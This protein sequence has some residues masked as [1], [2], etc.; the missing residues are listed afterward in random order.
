MV[1]LAHTYI[2]ENDRA[3]VSEQYGTWMISGDAS[4]SNCNRR[5]QTLVLVRG[6][7]A[8]SAADCG[9]S[10]TKRSQE[11]EGTTAPYRTHPRFH[12][13]TLTGMIT[14]FFT[15]GPGRCTVHTE[16]PK[17]MYTLFTHQY[18]WN[19]FK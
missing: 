16:W 1:H 11:V 9:T 14:A 13:T 18:L 3:H 12:Y 6:S 15:R 4:C 10:Q 8:T 17:K 5:S 2:F 7:V 19:K